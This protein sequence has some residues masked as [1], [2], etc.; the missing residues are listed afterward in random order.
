MLNVLNKTIK[1][2]EM[3]DDDLI[4]TTKKDCIKLFFNGRDRRGIPFDILNFGHYEEEERYFIFH[5]VNNMDIIFDIGANIGWYSLLFSKYLPKAKIF[6]FEPIDETFDFLSKNIKINNANNVCA[7]NC[8]ISNLNGRG[9]FYYCPEGSVIA[10]QKNLVNSSLAKINDCRI[11]TLDKFILHEKISHLD[12]IKCDIEGGE[13]FAL[14]GGE[15]TIRQ[16][17][18]IIFIELFHLWTSK[19]NYHPDDVINFLKIL[20]YKCYFP[21]GKNLQ[22]IKN[23]NIKEERLNYFFLHKKKHK[24][25]ISKYKL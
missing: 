5:F 23:I 1:K 21:T 19:F 17:L 16:F 25:L 15:K 6:S 22:E 14:Q 11:I 24:L 12:F 4:F 13:L 3:L 7:F 20:G 9:D 2:I 8:G 10:S 18:P